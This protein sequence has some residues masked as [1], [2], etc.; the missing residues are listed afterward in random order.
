MA[1]RK[2]IEKCRN[3]V[4]HKGMSAFLAAKVLRN[5]YITCK[6]FMHLYRTAYKCK[7]HLDTSTKI[8]CQG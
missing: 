5:P 2:K 3:T 7:H 8:Y 6:R 1:K 4:H